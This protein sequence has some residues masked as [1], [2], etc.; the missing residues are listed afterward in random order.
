L[1]EMFTCGQRSTFGGGERGQKVD[2]WGTKTLLSR[3]TLRDHL[4]KEGE[5]QREGECRR[6]PMGKKNRDLEVQA[7]SFEHWVDEGEVSSETEGAS[8]I[9]EC[10]K[11]PRRSKE[12]AEGWRGYGNLEQGG[13]EAKRF[14]FDMG[15]FSTSN[16]GEDH[17]Y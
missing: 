11:I 9:G 10:L 6:K 12:W 2:K 7:R 14:H 4:V 5:S 15:V 16:Q 13:A 1:G 3:L 17:S 8:V